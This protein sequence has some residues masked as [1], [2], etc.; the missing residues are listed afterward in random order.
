VDPEEKETRVQSEVVKF[1]LTPAQKSC[2]AAAA[3]QADTTVSS[4]VRRAALAAAEGRILGRSARIDTVAMRSAANELAAAID[5]TTDDP[6]TGMMR[7]RAAA[8]ELHRLA[9]RQLAAAR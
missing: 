2:L 5:A 6:D 9:A 3:T 8:A 4:M 1:R 7:V